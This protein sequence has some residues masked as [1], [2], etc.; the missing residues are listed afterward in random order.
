MTMKIFLL[1]NLTW[2][3]WG[4]SFQALQAGGGPLELPPVL[5]CRMTRVPLTMI[6]VE[7]FLRSFLRSSRW[8]AID[9]SRPRSRFISAG[10]SVRMTI[11]E[12]EAADW[13]GPE[14]G[15]W[16]WGTPQSTSCWEEQWPFIAT[17]CLRLVR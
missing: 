6:L 5:V 2:N 14:V 3:Y 9:G 11:V 12:L 10:R 4:L 7:I 15:R 16:R 17:N 13:A 1:Q 8:Y